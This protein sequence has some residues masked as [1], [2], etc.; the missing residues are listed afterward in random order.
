MNIEVDGLVLEVESSIEL[1]KYDD[2]P[3]YR[4]GIHKLQGTKGLDVVGTS[5]TQVV[6]GEVKNFRGHRIEN[7][8]K[9]QKGRLYVQ[10][11]EKLRDTVAGLLAIARGGSQMAPT[12]Q[13]I[14]EGLLAEQ[15]RRAVVFLY[16]DEDSST[17][18]NRFQKNRR[19]QE[20]DVHLKAL[21]RSTSWFPARKIVFDRGS[22]PQAL[23]IVA[24]WDA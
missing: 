19:K 12:S 8:A 13:S 10:V 21:K 9:L 5:G 16:V 23:G 4:K 14:L 1:H 20:L 24:V 2:W 7:K 17:A 6:L 15:D 22:I 18:G 11:A 3:A